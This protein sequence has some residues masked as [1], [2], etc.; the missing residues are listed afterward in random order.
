MS[1]NRYTLDELLSAGDVARELGLS[2]ARVRALIDQHHLGRLIGN[3][4]VL[5]P[6]DLETLRTVR[7][8]TAGRPAKE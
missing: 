5:T 6:D 3:S 1:T 7:R 2:M 8:P 4:H